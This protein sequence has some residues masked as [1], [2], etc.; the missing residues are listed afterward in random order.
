MGLK[1]VMT[2]FWIF[3]TFFVLVFAKGYAS[4]DYKSNIIVV[5]FREGSKLY[6]ELTQVGETKAKAA[7]E[8]LVGEFRLEP[9]INPKLIDYAQK[10][11]TRFNRSSTPDFISHLRRI[12]LIKYGNDIDPA[13]LSSKLSLAKDIEYAEP[14]FF[15][16]IDSLPND[17][18]LSDQ[19]YLGKIQAFAAWDSLRSDA[20]TIVVGIIDT[21]VDI[22][23]PDLKNNIFINYGEFGLDSA[24]MDKSSNGIDDDGNGY[25][26]DYVGWDFCG[27]DNTSPDNNPRP[28]NGH[29]THVAGI[30]GAV[31]NNSIGIAGVVPK[32]KIL[33]VKVSND[34][35]F[36]SYVSKGYEGILYA[37][38]MGAKVV[39]CSWGSESASNLEND[40]VKTVNAMDVCVV[41]AAGNSYRYSD[42]APA[43]FKGVLSVAAVDSNDIK[44]VFSNYSSNVDVS[45]P[46]VD[47]M[48]TVPGETYAAWDGTSMASP[49]ASGVVALIRQQFPNLN[50]E[51]AY[52]VVKLTADNIDSLN[53]DYAGYIGLGRV[54][55]FK[56]ITCN[57]DTLRSI[58]FDGYTVRDDDGNNLYELGEK[59]SVSFT[60]R[61]V[62]SN[63]RKVYLKFDGNNP[64]IE[65]VCQDSL[66]IGDFL[67]GERKTT[68]EICFTLSTT[69]P[70]DFNLRVNFTVYD[71]LGK[72]GKATLTLPSNPSYKTMGFNNIST[73]FNSRGNI[74]F[75][76]Y[77]L[78]QQGIGFT[79]KKSNNILFEGALLAGVPPQRVSD[80]AR[81]S[82]QN[83]QN[84][85]FITD[86]IFSISFNPMLNYY[87]GRSKFHS[88]QDSTHSAFNIEQNVY[89]SVLPEDSNQIFVSY[90]ITNVSGEN[91]DSLFVGLFFDWDISLMGQ[92][93]KAEYDWDFG[94]GYAFDASS[95]TLPY[96]GI[97]VFGEFP[98]NFYAI[99]ND[100]RGDDSIGIYDGFTIAEKWKMLSSG[101]LRTKSR[102]TDVSYVISAGPIRISNGETKRVTF[103]LFAG[104]DLFELRR[105][106]LRSQV[107]AS[108]LGL[109][110]ETYL[111]LNAPYLVSVFPNPTKNELHLRVSFLKHEPLRISLFDFLGRLVEKVDFS[112]TSQ[113]TFEYQFD[114]SLQ[115]TGNYYLCIQSPSRTQYIKIVKIE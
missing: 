99:D 41:A 113:A 20:D 102:I 24:G 44:A 106:S 13:L 77:P 114:L 89:Q 51:Q 62:L 1:F 88:S 68:D 58:L 30:V 75:N 2:R 6:D 85:G 53:P 96:V 82:N 69:I 31:A 104:K 9:A 17:L 86:S 8:S 42:Y 43:S 48:S 115:R 98:V 33:P 54:N 91:Y 92:S 110:S 50:Y 11:F 15:R 65:S 109:I 76:D 16:K 37:G 18:K 40:V 95:D 35:P 80:V 32:V 45:A 93:D 97:K 81:S 36:N 28:G 112:D 64:Y 3:C 55:A 21:G 63:L 73:T 46:G 67:L 111:K 61:S 26:D 83:Y 23:H 34:D 84:R 108:E 25:I 71:S 27:K 72:V 74:G 12:F 87:W 56:S 47:I 39:N 29:G 4:Q 14:L 90:N 103:G 22:D 49:V 10:K 94:F 59:L 57:I 52:E 70:L 79:H 5:K 19:Y 66:F 7:L 100:G 60:F 105:E 101:K 107:K 78:N 38:I